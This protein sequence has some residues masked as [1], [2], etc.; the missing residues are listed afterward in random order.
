MQDVRITCISSITREGLLAALKILVNGVKGNE[1]TLTFM[2]F[3]SLDDGVGARL[4]GRWKNREKMERFIRRDDVNGF[5]MENKEH[6]KA[7]EQR[8]YVPNGRGWLH[9]G[10]GHAGDKGGMSM[11]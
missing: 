11:L 3:A 10:S 7:M 4:F 2:A 9:R 8:L 5:W 1:G 6:V